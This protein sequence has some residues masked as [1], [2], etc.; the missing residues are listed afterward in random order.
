MSGNLTYKQAKSPPID[1]PTDLDT[2]LTQRQIAFVR[3]IASVKPGFTKL[4]HLGPVQ[5]RRLVGRIG[6]A[7]INNVASS[8]GGGNGSGADPLA[9]PA[10]T[11]DLVAASDIGSSSTDNITN[12]TT[13]DIDF[14]TAKNL[15]ENDVLRI[16]D[17]GVQIV[18][19][20]V[21]AGEA[22]SNIVPLGRSALSEGTHPLTATHTSGGHTS[23]ASSI[24]SV[25][26]DTTAPT[27]SN[28]TGTK[29][30]SSTADISIDVSEGSGI[31]YYVVDQNLTTPSSPQI[32]AGQDQGGA[33]ADK[34]G[35]IVIS[36]T[37]TK[38]VN[39][40]GLLSSTA[41]KAYFTK[42]DIAG[43]LSNASASS[44][45]TTDAQSGVI[46]SI[47]KGTITIGAAASSNTATITSVDTT[48]S[49]LIYEGRQPTSTGS[50]N[51]NRSAA[52]IALTNATTV[53]ATRQNTNDAVTVAFTVIE[54]AS[55]VN[56]IQS[57][58]IA[59]AG[60]GTS[61]T[62]TISAVGATA[63]VLW[64][65]GSTAI[66]ALN[67]TSTESSVELTNSTT[68][69][70]RCQANEQM[71]VGY[72]VVD[73]DSTIVTA[74]QQRA[75]TNTSGSAAFTDTITSL[76][77]TKTLLFYNGAIVPGTNSTVT[78]FACTVVLT[79]ATTV[80]VTRVG[81]NAGSQTIN[82]T[83]VTFAGTALNGGV[84][85]GTIALSSQT[86]NTAT[87]TSVDMTKSFVNWGNF[88][89]T[90]ANDNTD[91][92][93]LALTDATTVT[94]SVNSAGSPTASYEVLQ[95]A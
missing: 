49:I 39:I 78:S 89:C 94:A 32:R 45:F 74:V 35:S 84:Q 66:T 37:G 47:Q 8:G 83:A 1:L 72:M 87:I 86:S 48:K 14:V 91:I 67:W 5:L 20:S 18:L 93:T 7:V 52:R 85:R 73:L 9:P 3:S 92:P 36:S 42:E 33:S 77:T 70:A 12:D 27:I 76:D 4:S 6:G 88:K 19:H 21:T 46:Q 61:N 17:N 55:G 68:V 60:A 16:F 24:L 11:L 75:V 40:T 79:N 13:P 53:T 29:T 59:I 90:A 23:A 58:T 65:G 81:T 15:I 28:P 25:V 80:T 38:T 2:T 50:A 26:V 22:G 44:T 41:Y 10:P 34:F 43:N 71:T 69:T 95:F 30:G 54:F 63:F 82:Y 64:L 31:V 56:S 57:G 62:A 51:N